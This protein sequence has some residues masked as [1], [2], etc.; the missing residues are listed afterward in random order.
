[1]KNIIATMSIMLVIAACNNHK[2]V[3]HKVTA[4]TLSKKTAVTHYTCT[5]HP[6]IVT[7]T[8]GTCPK[9]GMDLVE[10]EEK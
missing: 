9:C 4:D 6:N 2:T 8:P 1:M 3:Q 5:M 10:K 7:T